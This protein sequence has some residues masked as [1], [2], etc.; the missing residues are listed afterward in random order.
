MKLQ[1]SLKIYIV[2]VFAE[3]N[4]INYFV[5]LFK[6]L[7]YY[8]KVKNCFDSS[9][10][11]VVITLVTVVMPTFYLVMNKSLEPQCLFLKSVS[12]LE[13]SKV[14]TK[15]YSFLLIRKEQIL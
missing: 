11:A 5:K 9:A 13:P 3:Y 8:F 4:T 15:C 2:D 7:T 14:P 10:S 6:I 12:H 1:I